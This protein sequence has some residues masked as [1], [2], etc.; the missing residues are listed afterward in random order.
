MWRKLILGS[1]LCVSLCGSAAALDMNVKTDEA[2]RLA[3]VNVWGRIIKGDEKN[4]RALVLPYVQA[5][6]L[7]YQV[8]IFRAAVMCRRPCEL[9]IRSGR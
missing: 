3:Y 1:A 9:R 2:E 8:N 5:G 4:F 6:Y 7:L